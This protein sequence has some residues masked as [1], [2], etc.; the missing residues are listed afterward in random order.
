[1]NQR[2]TA[3]VL[4]GFLAAPSL[5]FAA[6]A[7]PSA[8]KDAAP[9]AVVKSSPKEEV[10]VFQKDHVL[11]VNG[12]T[13]D[14]ASLPTPVLVRQKETMVPL[15]LVAEALGY[16]VSW[17]PET[18]SS[19]LD[20]SIASMEFRPGETLY[21][22]K[23]K[24][25]VINLDAAYKFTNAP[26]VVE[27]VTYVP[28]SLFG[29]FFNE[30][31]IE[32]KTISI[33]VQKSQLQDA[34][35]LLTEAAA[36]KSQT[37]APNPMVEYSS[38]TEMEKKVGHTIK[39]PASLKNK[40]VAGMYLFSDGLAQINYEDGSLY[41]TQKGSAGD[42]SGDYTKYAVDTHWI[43]GSYKIRGRGDKDAYRTLTWE[44]GIYTYSYHS[45]SALTKAAANQIVRGK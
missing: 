25:K 45:Q 22:R 17:N 36:E 12:K 27:G 10:G 26:Q 2:L 41:R 8:S 44:D 11:I 32:G 33:T 16:T 29:V 3:L 40:K 19:K 9:A 1:M 21:Q 37:Q 5:S 24:L 14:A 13:L 39:V 34:A 43:D 20:M 30:V 7:S 23:G 18:A 42:I 31:K 38:L 6:A 35:R 15:R 28:V 4:C